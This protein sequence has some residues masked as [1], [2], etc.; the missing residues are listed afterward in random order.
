M[1]F[2]LAIIVLIAGGGK[3]SIDAAISKRPAEKIK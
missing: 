1:L 2:A 3:A